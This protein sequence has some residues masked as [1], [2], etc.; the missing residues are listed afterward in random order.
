MKLEI[1]VTKQR[2]ALTSGS[3]V[4]NRLATF[5]QPKNSGFTMDFRVLNSGVPEGA[6]R[7]PRLLDCLFGGFL[8]EVAL[9]RKREF[10]RLVSLEFRQREPRH[11][12]TF[13]LSSHQTT[14]VYLSILPCPLLNVLRSPYNPLSTMP[15]FS[16]TT[17]IHQVRPRQAYMPG[18]DCGMSKRG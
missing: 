10:W 15:T 14:R 1:A 16:P 5:N 8:M 11:I 4:I 13:L 6:T 18:T 12:I 7:N 3:Y 2:V 9:W 17:P